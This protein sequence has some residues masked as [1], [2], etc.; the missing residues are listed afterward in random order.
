MEIQTRLSQ[1]QER[2]TKSES[3]SRREVRRRSKASL[4]YFAATVL[5]MVD[6]TP[7]LHLPYSNYI[8]LLPWTGGPPESLRKLAW[9][10]RGHFK[11]SIASVAF[12][13]WLLLHD[14]NTSIAL[15]S[16]KE[17][18]TQTWLREIGNN[19]TDNRFFNWA[20]PE[21]QKGDKWDQEELTIVRD[22]EYG[23]TRAP[24]VKA[25]TLKGGMAS[26][27]H[28]HIVLDDPLNEQTAF[29]DAEREKAITLYVHIESIISKWL[30]STFT[31]VGTPWPGYDVIQHAME[32][33]VAYGE[34]LFWGIGAR[35]GFDM[36]PSLKADFP[37]LVPRVA[38]RLSRDKVIFKEVCPEA[39]LIKIKR[40][41]LSQYY[42]QYLCTRPA[43]HDNG[44]D[45]KLVRD[46]ST[47]LEGRIRCDCHSTH[48][49]HLR[50]LV[51]VGIC[52]PALTTHEQG[53]ESA[54]ITVGRDP[55]C[56]CRF[57]LE[58]YGGHIDP[59]SLV[60]KMAEVMHRWALY[61]KRFA[62]EDVKFQTVFKSWLTEMQA[63][64]KVPLGI[65]LYGVKPK[66][67]DK[68][69]RIAGQQ[70]YV[71]NGLWH[72]TPEMYFEEQRE[73]LLWQILKWP[74]QPKKRDRIDAWAYCDD[75]WEGLIAPGRLH[76]PPGVNPTREKNRIRGVRDERRMLAAQ[77]SA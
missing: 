59:A 46:Y 77:E 43:D 55:S 15:I 47:S 57:V 14:R 3:E 74:G 52:D 22:A 48:E 63:M 33:E 36:S 42:Y 61:M 38:G 39:K 21:I 6:L 35:G 58:E 69:L 70:S 24:S 17:K 29:S 19:I 41:D 54:I 31:L 75:A 1:L 68:D 40:Q 11:S 60:D 8:Q 44:F 66:K 16:S 20:F 32:H 71:A 62:I 50:R 51:V 28:P 26:Q 18:N 4:Y 10:P 2:K 12:P 27:H 67:R 64:G 37:H 30:E 9:M 53:C 56:G 23:I 45:H 34:R 65:E 25:Y 49:H 73:N 72:K 7:D 13:L 5:Q 76:Q